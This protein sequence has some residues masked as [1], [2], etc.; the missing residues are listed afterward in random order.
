M[1]L[2]I[3]KCVGPLAYRLPLKQG[4]ELGNRLPTCP[5]IIL[6]PNPYKVEIGT[7]LVPG[8]MVR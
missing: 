1:T 8:S 4:G 6:I 2:A 5:S 3:K 7:T